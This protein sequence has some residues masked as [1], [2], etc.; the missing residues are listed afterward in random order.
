MESYLAI[1]AVVI[2]ILVYT[3]IRLYEARLTLKKAI[4]ELEM[5][6]TNQINM[7]GQ[8]FNKWYR[9]INE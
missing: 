7:Y 6:R 4:Q 9:E 2:M 5:N 8:D 1:L 3:V